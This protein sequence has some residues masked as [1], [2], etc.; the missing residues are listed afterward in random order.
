VNHGVER[1]AG[2]SPGAAPVLTAACALPGPVP[3]A[4]PDLDAEPETRLPSDHPAWARDV[5]SLS[6]RARALLATVRPIVLKV[7]SAWEHRV[8]AIIV[9][10]RTLSVDAGGCYRAD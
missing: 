8:R 6:Q 2:V 1:D 7:F 9:G 10:G 5:V 3:V 4:P